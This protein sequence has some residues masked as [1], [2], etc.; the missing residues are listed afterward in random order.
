MT[1]NVI[2]S[3]QY[4]GLSLLYYYRRLMAYSR[5]RGPEIRENLNIKKPEILKWNLTNGIPVYEVISGKN[6]VFKIDVVHQ[7]GRIQEPKR[8]VNRVTTS[9]MKEATKNLS[10]KELASKIDFYGAS[11]S[12]KATMDQSSHAIYGLNKFSSELVPILSEIIHE[13]TF[14]P[15]DLEKYK[16]RNKANLNIE[17]RKNDVVAYREFTEDIFGSDH[18][19]G[20]NSNTELYNS[21][22]IPEIKSHYKSNF[23]VNNCFI[24]LSGNITDKMRKSI[25]DLFSHRQNKIEVQPYIES[26]TPFPGKEKSISLGAPS[27]SAIILGKKLF[28]KNHSDYPLWI[29]LN[30]ILG[31]FFGSR[32]M[33]EIREEKGLTYNISSFIDNMRFDGHFYIS[34]EV[35]HKNIKDT[36]ESI[37]QEI[38]LL[39]TELVQKEE[40]EM[41]KNYIAGNILNMLDGPFRSIKWVKSLILSGMDSDDGIKVIEEI[42]S[43]SPESI[44]KLAIKYL[45]QEDLNTVIVS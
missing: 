15:E 27:Q 24:F 9:I 43:A 32:L 14:N 10:S 37:H 5:S 18:P 36:L 35:A 1:Q 16:K 30:T 45:N 19:Y 26:V 38:N 22:T 28:P 33:K 41:V 2:A 3:N 6:E 44:R 39:K 23:G 31:G 20:F 12:T 21:V 25:D 13:P 29:V 7:G 4:E 34:C 8:L 17:L 40:L 42:K 11:L